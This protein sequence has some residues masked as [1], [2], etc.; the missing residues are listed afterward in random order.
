MQGPPTQSTS[1]GKKRPQ[2]MV[3]KIS[4]DLQVRQRGAADLGSAGL[5]G[6]AHR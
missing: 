3:V 6:I 4:K 2:N 5:K 1:V